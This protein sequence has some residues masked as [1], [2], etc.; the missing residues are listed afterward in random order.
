[1]AP[2]PPYATDIPD[3]EYDNPNQK[4]RR[5]RLPKPE[6]PNS[7]SSAYDVYDNYLTAP[8]A[9]GTANRNSGVG[10]LGLGLMNGDISDSDDEDDDKTTS[11]KPPAS[12]HAALAAATGAPSSTPA[13]KSHSP[14]PIAA[15]RPGYAAPI[16][17]LNLA[18]PEPAASPQGRRSADTGNPFEPASQP[19]TPR[20]PFADPSTPTGP[21][22]PVPNRDAPPALRI[23]VGPPGARASPA[24]SVPS[25]PHPLQPPMSPIVPVFA[26]PAQTPAA[27][28]DV[29]FSPVIR[30]DDDGTLLAKR[31][32]RG[33]QFWRRFSMIAKEENQ[34]TVNEKQSLWLRKSQSGSQR[35]ARWVWIVGVILI[36]CIAGGIGLG[37]Y[38]SHN[39]PDHQQPTAIGGSANRG[40]FSSSSS[41]PVVGSKGPGPSIKTSLH[42]SPTHTVAR[43]EVLEARATGLPFSHRRRHT[44]RR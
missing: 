34:K 40:G 22:F 39:A 3:S 42:V 17:T 24:S 8:D 38:A 19:S 11:R 43:R 31:G 9:N 23:P 35:L 21:S 32:D 27:Q 15:P 41:V 5:T 28:R 44:L 18:R 20:N 37:W 14:P 33:D 30:G 16:A 4:T 29:K 26:R 12:K 6:N 13:A 36:L 1:M 7:R 25:S 10:A 2:M